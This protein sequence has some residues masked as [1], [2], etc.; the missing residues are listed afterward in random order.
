MS[1]VAWASI[2]F[3]AACGPVYATGG[4]GQAPA[5]ATHGGVVTQGGNTHFAIDNQSSLTVCYV[6]VSETSN[7]NWGPDRLGS[8]ETIPPGTSR[9]WTIDAGYWDFRFLDCN[10]RVL[11]ERRSVSVD[12]GG[13]VVTF[14]RAE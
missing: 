9:Y 12:G 4:G 10:Q 3:G 2:L 13:I 1:L 5:G 7:G 11:M 14:R 8:S 6:N